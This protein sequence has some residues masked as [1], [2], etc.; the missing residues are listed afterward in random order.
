PGETFLAFRRDPLRVLTSSVAEY[1]NLVHFKV[2]GQHIFLLN[3]PELINDLLV[4]DNKNFIK[5]RGL[6]VARRV[7]G[8]GL[9]TS[10]GEFHLRQRRMIQPAF[11]R[12]RIASYATTMVDYA[13][14][15]RE[16]WADGGTVDM[17]EEMMRLT[18]AIVAKTLFD[19]NVED[20]AREIGAAL[21]VT[22]NMFQRQLNPWWDWLMRLPL[23][24]TRRYE[25][26]RARLDQTIYRFIRERRASGE[27]RGDLLSMLLH[28][29]DEEGDRE[30]MTERQVRDEAMTLF[31]AGHETTAN[32]LTWTWYLLSQNPEAEGRMH[33]EIDAVL[34]GRIPTV[35]DLPNLKYTEMAL[36]ESMRL[37][38]PAW[39]VGRQALNDYR[40]GDGEYV[41]P[42]GSTLFASQFIMHRDPHFFPEPD[43]FKPERWTPERRASLPKFAYFPFGGGPR[44]CIGEP[45]A[46]M[47]G[48]LLLAA[49]GQ[50]WQMR[51]DPNQRVALLPQITLRPK[52][53]M[54]MRLERRS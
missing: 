36:T 4:T 22:I 13:N 14:K 32:A 18:L 11:H 21:T 39:I 12:Q 17:H 25:A 40:L 44:V 46:W 23:P 51:L 50:K 27:D 28:T 35:E 31:L 16:R 19:E 24:S 7:L 3:E 26:A 2:L 41:A 10:E 37:Y 42:E 1:G 30:R 33:A 20:E 53:G 54:R 34:G 9:L 8:N 43:R 38:P 49:L 47:E 48:V 6:A 52:Y 29:Q 45:F 5:S 15:A